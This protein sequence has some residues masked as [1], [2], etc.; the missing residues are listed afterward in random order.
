MAALVYALEWDYLGGLGDRAGMRTSWLRLKPAKTEITREVQKA[1]GGG[2]DRKDKTISA[3]PPHS[4]A[5]YTQ[6]KFEAQR[7]RYRQS[8]Y[9]TR[10]TSKS[11]FSLPALGKERVTS[12]FRCGFLTF[13]IFW[14][15]QEQATI[16][17][18]LVRVLKITQKLKWNP[19]H[20]SLSVALWLLMHN[21]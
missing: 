20:D 1:D 11:L 12:Y 3:L 21:S 16:T 4:T 17:A 13:T 19:T 9:Y 18:S 8:W 7:S 14:S 2:E 10:A 6:I 15:P 5:F